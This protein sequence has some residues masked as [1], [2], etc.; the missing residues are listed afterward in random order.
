MI[1]RRFRTQGKEQKLQSKTLTP[2]WKNN[3]LSLSK[4]DNLIWIRKD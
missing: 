1:V 4:F 3:R 2:F